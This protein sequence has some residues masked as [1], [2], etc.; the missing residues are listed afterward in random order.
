VKNKVFVLEDVR[1]KLLF[2]SVAV[3]KWHSQD[4]A[5]I[6]QDFPKHAETHQ[7]TR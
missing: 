6:G 4:A 3:A 2:V 5:A 1:L 7:G